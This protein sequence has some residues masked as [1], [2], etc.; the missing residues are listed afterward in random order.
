MKNCHHSKSLTAIFKSTPTENL[1]F[2]SLVEQ[3][4]PKP[5]GLESRKLHLKNLKKMIPKRINLPY[6]RWPKIQA[7]QQ[8]LFL[9]ILND[10]ILDFYTFI[11]FLQDVQSVNQDG[12]YMGNRGFGL[13]G[14][15]QIKMASAQGTE[16]LILTDVSFCQ[17]L[18]LYF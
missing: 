16:G 14:L 13:E 5:N 11:P 6:L 8:E 2:L 3:K 10:R 17:K 4:W 7:L 1:P 18:L 9:E 15:K 12:L